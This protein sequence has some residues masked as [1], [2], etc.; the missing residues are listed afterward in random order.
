MLSDTYDSVAISGGMGES[1]IPCSALHELIRITKPGELMYS[2]GRSL[3]S[4]IDKLNN[5]MYE[6]LA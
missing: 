3:V 5:Y 6:M 1:H 2:R 4:N